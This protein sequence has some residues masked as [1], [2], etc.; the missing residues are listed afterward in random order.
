MGKWVSN[1]WN[2]RQLL[3]CCGQH[4]HLRIASKHVAESILLPSSFL[5]VYVR[6]HFLLPEFGPSQA[7]RFSFLSSSSS[8]KELESTAQVE[9]GPREANQIGNE[10]ILFQIFVTF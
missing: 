9:E 8:L 6:T 4:G 1:K 7:H 3:V 10:A 2:R 5:W